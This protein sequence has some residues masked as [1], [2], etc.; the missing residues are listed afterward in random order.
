ME[1]NTV[2]RREVK[3]DCRYPHCAHGWSSQIPTARRGKSRL[4]ISTL[5]SRVELRFQL[6]SSR[7]KSRL[8]LAWHS[9]MRSPSDQPA[10]P[11]RVLEGVSSSLQ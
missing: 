5:R 6:L 4:Q 10:L 1:L 7:D 8:P 3:A 9:R 2:S 11:H